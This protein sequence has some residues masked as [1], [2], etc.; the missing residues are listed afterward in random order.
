MIIPSS[1]TDNLFNG[2]DYRNLHN[3]EAEYYFVFTNSSIKNTI[4]SFKNS[5]PILVG[6]N[7]LF[8]S[9]N[10]NASYNSSIN[11]VP[12]FISG[13]EYHNIHYSLMLREDLITAESQ[14]FTVYDRSNNGHDAEQLTNAITNSINIATA[15]SGEDKL[16]EALKY[17]IYYDHYGFDMTAKLRNSKLGS[18]IDFN[19]LRFMFGYIF[20]PGAILGLIETENQDIIFSNVQYISRYC[21]LPILNTPY[22]HIFS[23]DLYYAISGLQLSYIN[24]QTSVSF[25]YYKRSME[26]YEDTIA[27]PIVEDRT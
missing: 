2:E 23:L 10:P 18:F 7:N 22:E 13:R 24:T 4:N 20:R 11:N 9:I 14:N 26:R 5:L 15:I 6:G 8:P 3:G 21:G 17:G 1:S 25:D 27:N 12:S 16:V 19:T